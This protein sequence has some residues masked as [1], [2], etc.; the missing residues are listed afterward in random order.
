MEN[1]SSMKRSQKISES[2]EI[3]Y[4]SSNMM[5]TEPMK[6]SSS[7]GVNKKKNDD[8][9][10]LSLLEFEPSSLEPE[11]PEMQKFAPRSKRMQEEVDSLDKNLES[12]ILE[13]SKRLKMIHKYMPNK[14]TLDGASE[15]VVSKFGWLNPASIKDASRRRP[16]DP[17]YDKKTLYIP[18]G[19]L[20]KMTAS[21]RQ[22]WDIKRNYMDVVLFFKVVSWL[23]LSW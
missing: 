3:N 16:S 15:P 20:D 6:P 2:E 19:E 9:E 22:Y 13:S 4:R 5:S 23:Y 8:V 1:Q 7:Y 14:A 12:R 18:S 17:L 11:T 21:Q 10:L